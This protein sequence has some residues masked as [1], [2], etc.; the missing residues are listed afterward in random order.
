MDPQLREKIKTLASQLAAEEQQ[1]LEAAGTLMDLEL[2]SVEIAD[3]LACQLAGHELAR[4]GETQRR[5]SHFHCPDCHHQY[6]AELEPEAVI[7]QGL[8]G[9][10]QYNEPRCYCHRCRRSFFP[11]G[12]DS[13]TPAS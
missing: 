12:S 8:R 9:E 7:L 3:E 10:I 1:R 5:Q 6:P 13:P 4:R 11:S 2:L